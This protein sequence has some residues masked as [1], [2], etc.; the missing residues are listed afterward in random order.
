VQNYFQIQ[1]SWLY[2]STIPVEEEKNSKNK[3]I[4]PSIIPL[5]IAKYHKM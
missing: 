3:P 2:Y 5:P 1:A 4:A